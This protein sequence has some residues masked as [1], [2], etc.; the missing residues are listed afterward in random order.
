MMAQKRVQHGDIRVWQKHNLK[1]ATTGKH[2]VCKR[3]ALPVAHGIRC[4]HVQRLGSMKRNIGFDTARGERADAPSVFKNG[5]HCAERTIRRAV[6]M[7]DHTEHTRPT[8]IRKLADRFDH[9]AGV[10]RWHRHGS[11]SFFWRVNIALTLFCQTRQQWVYIRQRT[12]L[13]CVR[14]RVSPI[15][16]LPF[17]RLISVVKELPAVFGS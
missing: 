14:C 6:N 5:H 4:T 3:R 15:P 1:P 10:Q 17:N 12:W 8:R 11:L 7:G 9:G 2:D 13:K 16:H